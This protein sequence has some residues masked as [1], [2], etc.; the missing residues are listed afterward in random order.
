MLSRWVEGFLNKGVTLSE[1]DL[2]NTHTRTEGRVLMGKKKKK[3]TL[4]MMSIAELFTIAK[5]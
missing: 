2:L 4:E 5:G 1:L 3:Q